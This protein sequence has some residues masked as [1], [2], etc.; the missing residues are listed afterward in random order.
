MG[1]NNLTLASVPLTLPA[2]FQEACQV[3]ESSPCT[4]FVVLDGIKAIRGMDAVDAA[5]AYEVLAAL[6]Q[7]RLKE[8]Q[9]RFR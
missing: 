6:A 9:E 2:D 4:K 1:Q 5:N 8:V 7:Q 3:I